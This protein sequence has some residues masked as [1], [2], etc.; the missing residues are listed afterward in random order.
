MKLCIRETSQQNEPPSNRALSESLPCILIILI[1]RL[2]NRRLEWKRL[3]FRLCK[4][5]WF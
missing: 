1:I 5:V 4:Y 2:D 3:V